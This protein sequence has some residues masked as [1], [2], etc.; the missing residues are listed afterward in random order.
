MTTARLRVKPQTRFVADGDSFSSPPG[1]GGQAGVTNWP[2][3]YVPLAARSLS[4]YNHAIGGHTFIGDIFPETGTIDDK[5]YAPWKNIYALWACTNDIQHAV[6]TW[7]GDVPSQTAYITGTVLPALSSF[8]DGRRAAGFK[9]VFFTLQDMSPIFSIGA[10]CNVLRNIMN[11][12]TQTWLGSHYDA[13]VDLANSLI[14]PDGC[15]PTA[16]VAGQL[17]FVNGGSP[18]LTQPGQNYVETLVAAVCD[19]LLGTY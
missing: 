14:G 10:A 2:E 18:H 13:K 6:L 15:A 11:A 17:L 4:L 3:L 19:P 12:T 5:V 16:Q 8:L 1:L 9:V 7:P